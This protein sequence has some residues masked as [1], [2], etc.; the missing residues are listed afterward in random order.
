MYGQDF[1]QRID[2]PS[3]VANPVRGQLNNKNVFPLSVFMPE[4]LISRD[5]FGHPGPRQLAHSLHLG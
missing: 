1:Q 5:G 2:Q 4:N 3:M